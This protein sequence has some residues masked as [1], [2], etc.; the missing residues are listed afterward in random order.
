LQRGNAKGI[1]ESNNFI[2]IEVFVSLAAAGRLI[3]AACSRNFVG[4]CKGQ[5]ISILGRAKPRRWA[6][7]W[8]G[9]PGSSRIRRARR[10]RSFTWE[11]NKGYK[12]YIGS[13]VCG[14]KKLLVTF[15]YKSNMKNNLFLSD[16]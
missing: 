9:L 5:V 2:F 10:E 14:P 13:R 11:N 15:G 8:F 12:S 4:A 1:D 16:Y 7:H 3:R 6:C